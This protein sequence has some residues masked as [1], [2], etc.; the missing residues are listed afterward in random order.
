MNAK[1]KIYKNS[2]RK[3]YNLTTS[4]RDKYREISRNSRLAKLAAE[5]GTLKKV[6]E[7][8]HPKL[9]P[10]LLM[11]QKK[12][13]GLRCLSLFSGGGGLDLGFDYAGYSHV[14][15]YASGVQSNRKKAS[16]FPAKFGHFRLSVQDCGIIQGFLESWKFAGAVY[17]IL[18]Q[19]GNSVSPPVAYAVAV[20]VA[21]ALNGV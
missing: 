20:N 21:K 9:F 18:G 5:K 11:P 12:K 16:A 19:I 14:A 4:Q 1:S 13:N 8:N 17:Q 10:E 15:S 6:H 2:E 3:K 7:I